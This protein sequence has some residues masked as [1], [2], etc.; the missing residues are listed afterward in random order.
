MKHNT[1]IIINLNIRKS[2]DLGKEMILMLTP[3]EWEESYTY[4][5]LSLLK[6]CKIFHNVERFASIYGVLQIHYQIFLHA[7]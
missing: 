3:Y 4:L 7:K 6:E 2:Q 5:S 1:K